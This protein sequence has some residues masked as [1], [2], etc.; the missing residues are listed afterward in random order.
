MVKEGESHSEE[1]KQRKRAIEVRNNADALLYSTEKTLNEH[2]E[3]IS[4]EDR[5]AVESAMENLREKVKGED[6]A[7]IEA[8]MEQLSQAG[9]K[10]AEAM[11][12]AA[13]AEQQPGPDAG[14][15]GGAAE[16]GDGSAG[17]DEAVD[18]DFTVVDD[19]KKE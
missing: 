14:G 5:A 11:Y 6:A 13:S 4:A 8:A 12:Q 10:L 16:A 3:K 18:A 2:G 7:A 15:E 17:G 1:D 19:D 9:H